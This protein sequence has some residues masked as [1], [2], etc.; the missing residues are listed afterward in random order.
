MNLKDENNVADQ[1]LV[2]KV[3]RG[4]TNAFKTI[5]K[6]TEGL[7]AQI[8]FKMIPNAEDRKDIAQDIYLKT[9]QKLGTFKFQSKLSTWIGQI[10]YNTCINYLEKK[11]LV[12]L[13][14]INDDTESDDEALEKMNSKI[15]PFSNETENLI[16]KKELSE[17]LKN[18]IDNLSPVYKTLIT[19][20]HI[21]ELY[22][23]EI[24]EITELPEGTIKNYLF[25]ARK[26]L[27]NNLLLTYKREAL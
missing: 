2:D 9:F 4:N 7:V 8:V 21:E 23:S 10:A 19:L 26:T 14:N 17:I 15:E 20:Y 3:L 6:N 25:R 16:F 13:D 1:P 24:A 27:R 22:Y 18:E 12:L 5:I 11:K